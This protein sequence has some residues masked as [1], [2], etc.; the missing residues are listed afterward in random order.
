M[1]YKSKYKGPCS[2]TPGRVHAL[3]GTSTWAQVPLT[4]FQGGGEEIYEQ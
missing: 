2:G 3:P 4:T 1:N